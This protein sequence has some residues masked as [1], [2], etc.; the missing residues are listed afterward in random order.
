[1]LCRNLDMELGRITVIPDAHRTGK[2]YLYREL[3]MV[4]GMAPSEVISAQA[5]EDDL[6]QL[7]VTSLSVNRCESP[8]W[9]AELPRVVLGMLQGR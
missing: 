4:P 2:L 8:T 1:M 9:G 5:A 6:G 7:S 3:R